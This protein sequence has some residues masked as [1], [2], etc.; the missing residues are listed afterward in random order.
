MSR[1]V[2]VVG[3]CCCCWFDVYIIFVIP[4]QQPYLPYYDISPNAVAPPWV[5]VPGPG[6]PFDLTWKPE[7]REQLRR[8]QLDFYKVEELD[9]FCDTVVQLLSLNPRSNAWIQTYGTFYYLRYDRA[10]LYFTFT[11]ERSAIVDRVATTI[12]GEEVK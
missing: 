9:L 11:G 5:P 10:T 1:F 2:V 8:V 6:A 12:R 4:R 3:G 7:A